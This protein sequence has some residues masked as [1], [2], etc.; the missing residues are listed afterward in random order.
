MSLGS[1]LASGVLGFMV[2]GPIGAVAGVLIENKVQDTI[3]KNKNTVYIYEDED[4]AHKG[5]Y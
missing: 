1:K 5:E 4:E 2:G 3:E